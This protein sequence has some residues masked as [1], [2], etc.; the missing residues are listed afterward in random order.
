[1]AIKLF[2]S[3]YVPFWGTKYC[4]SLFYVYFASYFPL[5]RYYI[6]IYL[7]MYVTTGPPLYIITTIKYIHNNNKRKHTCAHHHIEHP[8]THIELWALS[9]QEF[10]FKYYYNN[11][12]NNNIFIAIWP[13]FKA[14]CM[15]IGIKMLL[16]AVAASKIDTVPQFWVDAIFFSLVVACDLVGVARITEFKRIYFSGLAIDANFLLLL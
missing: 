5:S 13:K 6:Y 3:T 7:E 12:N 15:K 2:T 14:L 16:F 4:L 11:S 1:M 10:N 9:Q 8:W